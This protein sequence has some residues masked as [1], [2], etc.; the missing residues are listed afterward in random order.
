[1]E[2]E[3]I[4]DVSGTKGVDTYATVVSFNTHTKRRILDDFF[5]KFP[6]A[7]EKKGSKLK[8]DQVVDMVAFLDSKDVRMATLHFDPNDWRFL[9]NNHGESHQYNE[10]MLGVFYYSLIRGVTGKAKND[11]YN[12]LSCVE[13]QFGDINRAF[14]HCKRLLSFSNIDIECQWGT[15][16]NNR[17]IRIPDIVASASRRC[18]PS[19]LNKNRNYRIIK[20]PQEWCYRVIF[21]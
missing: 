6:Q 21:S 17:A 9:T 7:I 10:K 2:L 4:F 13:S 5:L 15:G 18:K 19:D 12:V 14:H 8:K 16:D 3:F 11:R 1:M 20:R